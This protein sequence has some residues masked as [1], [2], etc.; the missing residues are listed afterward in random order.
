VA[1]R[2]FQSPHLTGNLQ[3]ESAVSEVAE[4]RSDHEPEISAFSELV[5]MRVSRKALAAGNC[6]AEKPP[7]RTDRSIG[8]VFHNLSAKERPIA[9]RKATIRQ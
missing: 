2:D 4:R 6:L 8:V 1:T 5:L 3:S 9:K 7:L